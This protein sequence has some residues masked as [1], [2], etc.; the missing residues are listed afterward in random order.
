MARWPVPAAAWREAESRRVIGKHR[1][2]WPCGARG[3]EPGRPEGGRRMTT[4]RRAPAARRP[5]GAT[6]LDAIL[7]PRTVAVIG[8]SRSEDAI[9]HQ[10]LANLVRCGFTGAV[11]P[12]NPSAEAIHSIR[13]YPSI[14]DVPGPVDLA[15]IAVPAPLVPGVAAECAAK[16]VRGLV[17]ISAGF[18]EVGREGAEREAALVGLVRRHGMRLV[19]PN[20]LGVLNADASVSMNATF[21]PVMPP[22]GRV[23]FLS[24]SGALGLSIL[25]YASE[26]RVGISQ[27]VSVGN[28]P[29]VS[30][31]DLLE[32][33]E[34]DPSVSV[35][36]M[37]V[38]SFG[39]PQ[40]FREIAARVSRKKPIIALKAGRSKAG[41]GAALS[42]TG[43]LAADE[44]AV[45]ALLAQAGV[46]RAA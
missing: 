20:C 34:D 33:W 4:V 6:G 8:A 36:L 15:V 29:D 9:G 45:E 42:H 44:T 27:F 31:N 28:K 26:Y 22:P 39:N 1:A 16:G 46:L 35:I 12:V 30:G 32:Y 43:A 40:K 24:Q 14:A 13:A 23:A 3:V 18:R 2:V 19:G 37:Y 11:F 38:E 21:A 41:A 7:K 25:D 10:I 17:V 5:A